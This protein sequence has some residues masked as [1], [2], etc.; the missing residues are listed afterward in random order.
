M[1]LNWSSY[2]DDFCLIELTPLAQAADDGAGLLFE[3][4]GWVVAADKVRPFL[5]RFELLGVAF[6]LVD[7][8]S[9]WFKIGNK[10]G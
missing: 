8:F 5:P 9:G 2:F 3:S 7:A 6:D 10:E 1:Y 4:L